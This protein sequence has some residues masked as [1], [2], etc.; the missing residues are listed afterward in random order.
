MLTLQGSDGHVPGRLLFCDRLSAALRMRTSETL[1]IPPGHGSAGT[2]VSN[3]VAYQLRDLLARLTRQPADVA[4]E[5]GAINPSAAHRLVIG[6]GSGSV[7]V[8]I[9]LAGETARAWLSQQAV[10]DWCRPRAAKSSGP[11]PVSRTEAIADRR[12][13]YRL[14]A[15][16]ASLS[17]SDVLTLQPGN[18]IRL[19]TGPDQ[20]MTL[21]TDGGFG[22]GPCYLGMLNGRPVVQF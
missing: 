8:T 12:L 3:V 13:R 22:F 5:A 19:D 11:A 6:H 7:L 1:G 15:G 21:V 18:V 16:E 2:L 17:L 20:P 9:H 10:R 4:R 14:L